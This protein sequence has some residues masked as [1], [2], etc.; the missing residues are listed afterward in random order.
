MRLGILGDLHLT[1]RGPSRRLDNYFETQMDKLDQSF[2]IFDDYGCEVI[3][4]PGDFC[5]SPT[6]SDRVKAVVIKFLMER[7]TP[8]S[9][10]NYSNANELHGPWYCVFGQHDISGHSVSTLP[11]SPLAVLAAAGVV[12]ILSCVDWPVGTVSKD[13][14]V[15]V[16]LYGAGFGELV[17]KPVSRDNYNVLVTHR[18]IGDRPLYPGQELANPRQFLRNHPDY[19]L[20]I[21]GDY[22]YRFADTY[23]GRTIIN[24]G[25]LVR[26]TISKFDLEHKPAV[27]VFDT[28]TNEFEFIELNV[29]PAEEVFD[30]SLEAKKDNTKLSEFIEELKKSKGRAK[31]GCKEILI[32]VIE[33][34]NCSQEV[35]DI[36]DRYFEEA[37][38]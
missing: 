7:A 37:K 10:C 20:V 6:I 1:N 3:I 26:K 19:N 18:M 15:C 21:C 5:D 17:P 14:D 30:F 36:I 24:P 4:Q 31:A 34:R 12:T 33:K 2:T 22:H 9:Y 11:N 16:V 38:K 25:A 13:S 32:K 35:R 29:K 23:C 8:E 27:A 28:S